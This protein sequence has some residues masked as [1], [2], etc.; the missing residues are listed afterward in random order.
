MEKVKS[1]IYSIVGLLLFGALAKGCFKDYAKGGN[2]ETIKNCEAVIAEKNI[3]TAMY[4]E[5]YIETTVKIMKVP[6]KTY[7]FTYKFDAEGKKYSGH[8]SLGSLPTS[9]TLSVYYLKS[10]PRI[11]YVDPAETLKVEKEKE[12]SNGDLYW[13]IWWS[14]LALIMLVS[15]FGN[16]VKKK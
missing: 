5:N 3:A 1:I 9:D 16:F 15:V 7:Q 11:N 8:I 13:G 12:S 4:D 14:I 6:T 2:K 10:N